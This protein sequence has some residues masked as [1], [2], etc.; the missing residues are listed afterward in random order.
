MTGRD[1]SG[2]DRQSFT[3]GVYPEDQT[4]LLAG[5][6]LANW[7][8]KYRIRSFGWL[9]SGFTSVSNFTG[10][11]A[12]APTPNRFS[13]QFMLD[14]AWIALERSTTK[15]LSWGFRA[16]FYLGSDAALLRSQNHFG[17]DSAR[18]GTEFR[19]AY[20]MLHT[21]ILFRGGIDWTAGKINLPTGVETTLSPYNQLYSRAY[22]WIHDA[23]SGTG[24]LATAHAN[25]QLDIVTGTT[26]GYNT[27]FILRGRA[28]S[29]IGKII[30]HPAT[31]RKQ[32]FIA[33]L[34]TGPKPLAAAANHVGAWQTLVELQAREV[35]TTRFNQTF[36]ISYFADPR[37]PANRRGNSGSQD[38]FVLSSY[39]LNRTVALHWRAEWFADPHGA[40]AAVPGS[41]GEATAGIALHPK[42]WFELRPEI[43]GDFS[44]QRSFGAADS[45]IRHRNQLSVGLELLLKARFF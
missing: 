22:F 6:A 14:A 19:Q 35:W 20:F 43:R 3:L 39:E 23:S 18:W 36:D 31:E 25:P 4:P 13:D 1:D 5:S 26:M 27:S 12:E 38:A 34:Y 10:L 8:R 33:T 28:P 30:Y 45:T 29:Y 15:N 32:Q 37:D 9:D 2:A 7:G 21:P 17:F 40:R 16:D 42:P 44:G 11:V 24:L 41:Y